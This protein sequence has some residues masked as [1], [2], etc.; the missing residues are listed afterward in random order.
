[1]VLYFLE[2]EVEQRWREF[3]AFVAE[4]TKAC[5]ALEAQ[6]R[7]AAEPKSTLARFLASRHVAEEQQAA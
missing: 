2:D 7:Q 3:E 1:M 6:A 4:Y 5:E